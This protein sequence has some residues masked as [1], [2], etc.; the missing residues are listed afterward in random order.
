MSASGGGVSGTSSSLLL[1][2][3]TACK[4][5]G[6][7]P[8]AVFGEVMV[9]NQVW[10]M[11]NGRPFYPSSSLLAPNNLGSAALVALHMAQTENL[12]HVHFKTDAATL[13]IKM[14]IIT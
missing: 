4:A 10:F 1:A 13:L 8:T 12:S 6:I 7:R 9:R 11:N 5:A 2:M 3:K 14:K